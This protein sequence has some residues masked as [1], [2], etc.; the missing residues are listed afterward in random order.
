MIACGQFASKEESQDL[1]R[2]RRKHSKQM[3][4]SVTVK[5][6][7]PCFWW[8]AMNICLLQNNMQLLLRSQMGK[9]KGI[10]YHRELGKSIKTRSGGVL[11]AGLPLNSLCEHRQ[12]SQEKSSLTLRENK[13]NSSKKSRGRA[14]DSRPQGRLKSDWLRRNT[15]SITTEMFSVF[16]G[17]SCSHE[18]KTMLANGCL[19]REVQGLQ[20]KL[21]STASSA[22]S[23]L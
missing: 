14:W 2:S 17:G 16:S 5:V 11:Q 15:L 10:M 3:I 23:E 18:H 13:C 12:L 22:K 20:N 1:F 8:I 19:Q 9:E 6:T 4:T 21:T 7:W